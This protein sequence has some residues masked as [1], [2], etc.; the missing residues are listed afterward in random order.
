MSDLQGLLIAAPPAPAASPLPRVLERL[1]SRDSERTTWWQSFLDSGPIE[2]SVCIANWNCRE[3]LRACLESLHDTPQG[4]R[5]ETI[6]VE[7]WLHRR[8]GRHGR[9]RFSRGHP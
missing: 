6:V 8:S 4:V 3:E 5:L 7:Q 2:V 1:P 9:A